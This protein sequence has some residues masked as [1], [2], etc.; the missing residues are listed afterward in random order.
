MIDTRWR[1][2]LIVL[3]PAL[4]APLQ[5]LLFGPHTLHAGN[6]QEFSASF[7]SLAVHLVPMILAVSGGLV[8]LGIALPTGLFRYYVVFL[9]GIGIVVWIQGNLMVGD[10][11]VLNGE[12]VDWSGQAWRN[13]HELAIWIGLPVLATVVARKVF[14]HGGLRQPHLDCASGRAA[15]RLGGTGRPGAAGKV[16]GCS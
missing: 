16:A 4:L 2:F 6:Q 13:R 10:Y 7:W 8:L 15:R 9:V 14:S 11:G 5:L 3:A 1:R 12:D